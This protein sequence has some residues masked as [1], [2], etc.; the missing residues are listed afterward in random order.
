MTVKWLVILNQLTCWVNEH[1]IIF[2]ICKTKTKHG[3]NGNSSEA[4]LGYFMTWG[5]SRGSHFI[6]PKS[7]KAVNGA[8]DIVN[9]S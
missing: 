4:P 9:L 1:K 3:V 5:S 8:Y 7:S 2:Q 6:P